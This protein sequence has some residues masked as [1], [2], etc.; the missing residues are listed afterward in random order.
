MTLLTVLLFCVC[1]EVAVPSSNLR[2]VNASWSLPPAVRRIASGGHWLR[3][4]YV[5][6]SNLNASLTSVIW[7]QGAGLFSSLCCT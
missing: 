1:L 7:S 5:S 2:S 4:I 3:L 6:E